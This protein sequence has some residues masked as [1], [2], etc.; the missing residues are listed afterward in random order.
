MEDGQN[1]QKPTVRRAIFSSIFRNGFQIAGSDSSSRTSSACRLV[2]VLRYSYARRRVGTGNDDVSQ[3]AVFEHAEVPETGATITVSGAFP[4]FR[5]R[6]LGACLAPS[7]R[8]SSWRQLC[9]Q[10]RDEQLSCAFR[11]KPLPR[12]GMSDLTHIP[13]RRFVTK[14]IRG[15]PLSGKKSVRNRMVTIPLDVVR[16]AFRS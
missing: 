13:R 11:E 8:R 16:G 9:E 4:D 3:R 7:L 14:A 10:A 6:R 1:R 2:P 12:N 15:P 5:L